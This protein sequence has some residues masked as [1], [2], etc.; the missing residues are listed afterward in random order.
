L[1]H[2]LPRQAMKYVSQRVESCDLSDET[3]NTRSTSAAWRDP[4][5][6]LPA[7]VKSGCA[8]P[9]IDRRLRS[10]LCH[11][12]GLPVV[13]FFH[14]YRKDNVSELGGTEEYPN[15]VGGVLCRSLAA[16]T[17]VGRNVPRR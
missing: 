9:K 3:N 6:W 1:R 14:Y 2:T 12:A 10:A 7:R 15:D 17:A 13:W 5:F 8:A 11:P 4:Q 16:R